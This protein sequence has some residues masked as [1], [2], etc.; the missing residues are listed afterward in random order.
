MRRWF[1]AALVATLTV[2]VPGLGAHHSIASIYDRNRSVTIEGAVV[3]FQF[4]NPHP[5]VIVGVKDET[6][7]TQQWKLEMDNR[8]E[9]EELGFESTTL[10]PGD[11]IVV[12]GDLARTQPRALYVRRLDRPSDVSAERFTY[13]HH[14]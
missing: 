5:F 11:R 9:L 4:I 7:R 2:P 8:F 3:Q 6:G 14:P 13:R 12:T 1:L 10:K